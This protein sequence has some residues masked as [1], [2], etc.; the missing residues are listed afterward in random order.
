MTRP[1]RRSI[2]ENLT[3]EQRVLWDAFAQAAAERGETAVL[4]VRR[5]RRLHRPVGNSARNNWA[6]TN[7]AAD[8]NKGRW[9][10]W[11]RAGLQGGD[12]LQL[13]REWCDWR[14]PAQRGR[15]MTRAARGRK[16]DHLLTLAGLTISAPI[17]E[18][19]MSR[20]GFLEGAVWQADS[21]GH[22]ALPRVAWRRIG[23]P[24][25]G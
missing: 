24:T 20:N 8:W 16:Q 14:S 19:L 12:I 4:R 23:E 25:D 17:T 21:P 7:S 9:L 13:D 15:R 2:F 18:A 1:K 11:W 5:K 6:R 3:D 10:E 22:A